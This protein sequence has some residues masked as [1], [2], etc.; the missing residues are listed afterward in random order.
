VHSRSLDSRSADREMLRIRKVAPTT[1]HRVRLTLTNGDVV[2]RDLS[3]LLWGP[4]LRA[5]PIRRKPF[6]TS[7]G[8]WG[9]AR[10]AGRPRLRSRHP[11]LGRPSSGRP[12][13]PPSAI[14]CGREPADVRAPVDTIG[15]IRHGSR[16]RARPLGW[17]DGR[18]LAGVARRAANRPGNGSRAA[19]RRPCSALHPLFVAGA[20]ADAGCAAHRPLHPPEFAPD[21]VGLLNAVQRRRTGAPTS[22]RAAEGL[23]WNRRPLTEAAAH[24]HP[25]SSDGRADVL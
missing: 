11:D 10:V 20:A 2:E 7:N 23:T 5:A 24:A 8:Q 4:R 13:H 12:E 15:S 6:P 14:S 19:E 21:G 18:E 9:H 3:A 25:V 17:A 22:A 16:C 1:D